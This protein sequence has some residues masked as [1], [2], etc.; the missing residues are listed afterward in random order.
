MEI[1]IRQH[2]LPACRHGFTLLEI[3]VVIGVVSLI[4]ATTLFSFPAFSR[5]IAIEQEAGQLALSI[6]KAQ[7]YSIAVRE[8][9]PGSG[10]FP[11]YG[12]NV[13]LDN[14]N[15]H[16]IFGDPNQ[17][18]RYEAGAAEAIETIHFNSRVKISKICGNSQSVPPG[19]CDLVPYTGLT[20]ADIF[21]IRPG[22]TATFTGVSSGL[23]GVYNDIKVVLSSED[24]SLT[25]SVTVWPTGQVSIQ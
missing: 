25:K 8:F 6:R 13:S 17:T 21:Y 16:V 10:I 14:P 20:S 2:G 24:N 12:V 23:S 4:A 15:E 7:S 3:I 1:R 22:P 18:N 19:P 9:S 11:G 5:R